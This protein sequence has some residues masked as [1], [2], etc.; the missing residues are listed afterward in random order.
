MSTATKTQP[1]HSSIDRAQVAF[2]KELQNW[3]IS[4][5]ANPRPEWWRALESL[6]DSLCVL[7]PDHG[8]E[9]PPPHLYPAAVNLITAY[10]QHL[11][12][13]EGPADMPSA[14]IIKAT[15]ELRL[16]KPLEFRR[17]EHPCDL[18]ELPRMTTE[19]V[20]RMTGL[21]I[22]RVCEI[23]AAMKRR[24]KGLDIDSKVFDLP[25]DYISPEERRWQ[26]KLVQEARQFR[27]AVNAWRDRPSAD[28]LNKAVVPFTDAPESVEQLLALP[29]MTN[30]QIARMKG[31]TVQE[32]QT[33]REGGKFTPLPP[34]DAT[35]GGDAASQVPAPLP[36]EQIEA[37]V[38]AL[39]KE[40]PDML[41]SGISEILGVPRDDVTR[42][43]AKGPVQNAVKQV[44]KPAPGSTAEPAKA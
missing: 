7:N 42:I 29:G 37:A 22:N 26:A 12:A 33:V 13:V 17:T 43:L 11:D 21:S 39:A 41:P 31:L 2:D 16:A 3:R 6:I 10:S 18:L 40:R 4:D 25:A 1:V 9:P 19:Q 32:V 5:R 14:A 8:Q 27:D 23:E 34:A 15:E 35:T 28:S 20:A 44:R 24:S 30:E 36:P 38:L